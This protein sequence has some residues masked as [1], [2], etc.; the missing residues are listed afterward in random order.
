MDLIGHCP[1]VVHEHE[2]SAAENPADEV[3]T[4]EFS[5]DRRNVVEILL[6]ASVCEKS[7]F[8]KIHRLRHR[9]ARRD[10]VPVHVKQSVIAMFVHAIDIQ[11]FIVDQCGGTETDQ[12]LRRDD[13]TRNTVVSHDPRCRRILRILHKT[14]SA[15][16]FSETEGTLPV[17][18]NLH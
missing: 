11:E 7:P 4:G 10:Q 15:C 3:F 8:L 2:F 17:F 12:S 14:Q 1:V 5:H 9:H 16:D 13:R 18:F 6:P